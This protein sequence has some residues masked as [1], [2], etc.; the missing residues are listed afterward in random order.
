VQLSIVIPAY[1]EASRIERTI[2]ELRAWLEA[3]S[4]SWEIRVVDDGSEDATAS[5]AAR[6]GRDDPRIV[7][8]RA[9]H[10]GK[11]AAVRAGLLTSRG[12]LRFICDADLA[13]PVHELA[14]FLAVVPAECD[15][16][17]GSRQAPGARRSG[18]PL[19][20]LIMS[21]VFNGLVRM[22]LLP[23]IDDTQCGFKL[24][25]AR[26]VEAIFPHVTLDGWAFDAEVMYVARV[27]RQRVKVVP[28]EW[29]YSGQSRVSR[30]LDPW[31][32]LADVWRI[33]RNAWRGVY[34]RAALPQ[35]PGA[36]TQAE[37]R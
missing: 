26:A 2:Q 6:A 15:I 13:M 7:V 20:R 4:R 37:F 5:M 1:N 34:D 16:A 14:R 35:R 3:S 36:R 28:I 30:L 12:E 8:Q 31:R 10:R 25:T 33:R 21:R 9:P 29:R 23:G 32:M 24:F 18:E 17:I 19:V 11:G 22:L 27:K